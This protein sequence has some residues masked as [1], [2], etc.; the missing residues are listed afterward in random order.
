VLLFGFRIVYRIITL[1]VSAVV[2]YLIVC[3]VQVEMASRSAVSPSRA[4]RAAAIVVTGTPG[5]TKMSADFRAKLRVASSL[6]SKGL[7]PVL[8]VAVPSG[9]R[10]SGALS[11]Q[12]MAELAPAVKPS[13]VTGVMAKSAGTEFSSVEKRIGRGRRVIVVTDAINSLYME[14]VAAENG[15]HAEV[16]APAAS[17][18]IVFAQISPLFRELTGVAVGRVFGFGNATWATK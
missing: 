17:K 4:N 16:V 15:L 9:A 13:E 10:R 6:Y 7:A 8:I 14:G 5:M 2:V 18:K 12:R 1:A 11:S 3:G